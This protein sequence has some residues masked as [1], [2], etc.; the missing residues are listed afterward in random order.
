MC[1]LPDAPPPSPPRAMDYYHEISVLSPSD[2]VPP[3]ASP[4]ENKENSAPLDPTIVDSA[5][6]G[7]PPAPL[8]AKKCRRRRRRNARR[9]ANRNSA[10]RSAAPVTPDARWANRNSAASNATQHHPEASDP[11]QIKSTSVYNRPSFHSQI[12]PQPPGSTA[13]KNSGFDL[14]LERRGS[15]GLY[16]L[17]FPD[18]SQDS[19]ARPFRVNNSGS[20]L[21]SL[22]HLQPC[23]KPFSGRPARLRMTCPIREA[24]DAVSQRS[25]I[26]YPLLPRAQ[27][28]DSRVAI[29]AALPEAA[30]LSRQ[31]LPPTVLEIG[32]TSQPE[33][34]PSTRRRTSR[35]PSR[36]RRC[37][38]SAGV[39]CPPKRSPSR[40]HWCE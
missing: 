30:A 4:T 21:S 26:I 36:K 1:W 33:P 13:N 38:R 11:A 17:A 10:P 15:V 24:G 25:G 7:A 27:W 2:S 28:P 5:L 8:P 34:E 32:N 19:A 16:K 18:P 12:S 39:F 14:G 37:N 20:G 3:C 31:D 23:T 6:P 35:K 22:P 40:G 9:A 29:D